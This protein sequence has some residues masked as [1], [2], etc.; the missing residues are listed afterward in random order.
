VVDQIHGA[1]N[2]RGPHTLVEVH[3][4]E[5]SHVHSP[6]NDQVVA[7]GAVRAWMAALRGFRGNVKAQTCH[8]AGPETRNPGRMGDEHQNLGVVL[9]NRPYPACLHHRRT[10]RTHAKVD[11][12]EPHWWRQ[13]LGNLPDIGDP[14]V[15]QSVQTRQ[16]VLCLCLVLPRLVPP[17]LHG[18]LL[19]ADP[20]VDPPWSFRRPN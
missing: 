18:H 13:E 9:D 1:E 12:R 8:L 11:T 20:Q 17:G 15:L 16:Q 6:Y 7:A 14:Q 10:G 19:L 4:T 5:Q 2:D 3:R